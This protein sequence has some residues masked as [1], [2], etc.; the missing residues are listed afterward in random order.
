MHNKLAGTKG[1]WKDDYNS[2]HPPLPSLP[3][4]TQDHTKSLTLVHSL[5]TDIR[6]KLT[7]KEQKKTQNKN[8]KK[9]EKKKKTNSNMD[10]L[11]NTTFSTK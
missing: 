4:P 5:H 10:S 8:Q 11:I 3:P 2:Q 1:I 6:T 9:K 7:K